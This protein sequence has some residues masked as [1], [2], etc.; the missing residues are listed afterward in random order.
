[1]PATGESEETPPAPPPAASSFQPGYAFKPPE[2]VKLAKNG[3]ESWKIWKQLWQH[4][5]IVSNADSHSPQFKKSLL[6]STMGIEALQIYNGCDP[7]ETDTAKDILT[8]LDAHILGETNE[9][10]ERYKFN[11]RVQKP[12]ESI[13][14]YVASLKTLAETCNFCE[15]LKTSLLRDRVVLGVKDD[16]TRK[17]LLQE[18][19]LTLQKAL[20]ICHSYEKTSDQLKIIS[21]KE[22]EV[23]RL[24]IN[25]QKTKGASHGQ[26]NKPVG[27]GKPGGTNPRQAAKCKFCGYSHTLKKEFCKAWG[28][29]CNNCKAPN[30]FSSCCPSLGGKKQV[31]T[32]GD[33][34]DSD[35][36]AEMVCPVISESI[37][38][39]SSGP[40]YAEMCL[41]DGRRVKF[42]VDCG[43]TVNVINQKYVPQ[44]TQLQESKNTLSMYNK[45]TLKPVGKCRIITINLTTK[46]KYNVMF[47]VVKEDL[48]PLLSRKAAEQMKLITVNY[49]NFKQVHVVADGFTEL[50]TEYKAVFDDTAVGCFSGKVNLKVDGN[51]VP[52]QSPPRRVPISVKPALEKELHNLVKLG[53]LKP[54]T[55]PTQW[56]SQISIQKKKNDQLRICLDPRVLN[57]ALQREIYPL[58]T[59][60]DI[61]PELA[62]AKLF[63]KFDLAH[64]YW[65]CELDEESSYMTTFIT[66]NGRFRWCRL[67]FG[68]KVSSE[69][70][71]RK[72]ME[73]LS[74]LRGVVCVADDILV[75]GHSEGDHDEKLRYLLDV[76]ARNNI[77][78]NH[79]KSVFKTTEVE[80]LGHVVT[81]EGLKP[82]MK[83]VEAILKMENPTDV[84]GAR[85]VQGMVTYL[86]KF[87]PQLSTVMDPIRRLTRQDV[88]WEW[89]EEQDHA[90]KEIKRLVT[91][92]PVLAYYD[93]DKELVIQCDAS[94]TGLGTVLLQEGKPLCYASRALTAT[95]CG[96]AQIEKECLAIVFSLERFHQYTFG[97][98][99]IV[100]SDH[101][102]LEMIVRKPLHKSPKRL[103]GM[104]LRLIQYDIE[105]VY[106]KGKEMYIADTLSRAYLPDDTEHKDS[107]AKINAVGHLRIREERLRQLKKATEMDDTLQTLKS[108][109]LK[110]W[111]DSRQEL[112]T[113]VTPYF[114]YRDEL[115]LHDGLI[116]KGERVIV[117]ESMRKEIKDHLHISHLGVDTG[118]LTFLRKLTP[119]Q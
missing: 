83:K 26:R 108:V 22:E 76:C 4:Y 55:E 39:V 15:C 69:I 68:L 64:G 99:T 95:E 84:E 67:P 12:D 37:N 31:H 8:K 73:S 6:I 102:P 104:M 28:K 19:K 45:T 25:K 71:Q 24:N 119:L 82:D 117:P 75:Y 78:L 98:K 115:T 40:L 17:R 54:V 74:G 101:K 81:S 93:P 32:V 18:G 3:V 70:F 58:P 107:F 87:L 111:P 109:I 86:A 20:D 36:S 57:E 53:V 80:F 77:K 29:R 1:M 52:T 11:T 9:T 85:R 2:P 23:H 61:L 92:A 35:S 94:S 13:D 100:H 30:H 48:T 116:F 41:K 21:G 79:Q 103:Q 47:E 49:D 110:G 38:S 62:N 72:L 7:V 96:Y 105:V 60:D 113:Q 118:K 46:K 5:C 14:S 97:R 50:V 106:K 51:A 10:F 33:G 88:E 89:S 63:S 91:T 43:A 16:H 90:M 34:S 114:S 59:I 65:H 56:C 27:N 42:Q 66:V 112:P 44:N